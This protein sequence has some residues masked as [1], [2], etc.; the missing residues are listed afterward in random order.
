MADAGAERR[1][2]AEIAAFEVMRG[3]LERNHMGKFVVF[4]GGQ[5]HDAFDTLETAGRFAARKFG[6]GPYLIRQVG[7]PPAPLP[8]SVLYQPVCH[9]P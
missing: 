9:T 1:I 5:F 8:A 4:H 6:R 2:E 3:E 7:R